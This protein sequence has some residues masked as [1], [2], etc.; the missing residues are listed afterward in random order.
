M[1]FINENGYSLI[2]DE[3]KIRITLSD[4]ARTIIYEDMELFNVKQE[5]T[6]INIVFKNYK[7]DAKSSISLYLNERKRELDKTLQ[8]EK[9]SNTTKKEIIEQL[10]LKEKE[11]LLVKTKSLYSEK[12]KNKIHHINTEN[13]EYLEEDCDEDIYYSKPGL[14]I[15][16]II[17]E[18]TSLP[19]I[20][21]ERIL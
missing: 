14:Y 15:R 20:K 12:G 13:V 11:E 21:R 16:C 1:G 6:F 9:I 19:F 8:I 10:L 18:Y 17:E 5:S 7:S 3:H 2:N 4:R